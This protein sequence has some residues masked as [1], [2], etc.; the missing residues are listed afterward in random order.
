RLI[1]GN[2]GDVY[3][4]YIR[5]QEAR[6]R[7]FTEQ[8]APRIARAFVS[9]LTVALVDADGREHPVDLDPTL[10]SDYRPGVPLYV[11]LNNRGSVP[12]LRREQIT[13][14]RIRT[15]EELP[16]NSRCTVQSA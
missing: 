1:G 4:A 3:N 7:I 16:P 15:S 2:A 9:K 10:V 11:R 13:G 6:D 5:N 14:V 12:A 8:L